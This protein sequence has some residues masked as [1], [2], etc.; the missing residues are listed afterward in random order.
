VTIRPDGHDGFRFQPGQFAWLTA[1]VSPFAIEEHPFSFSS[2]AEQAG[3]MS[4]TI[5]ELGDFTR[6]VRDLVPGQAVYLDGPYGAFSPDRHPAPG[7]VLIAGGVGI[8]PMMSILRTYADRGDRRPILLFYANKTWEDAIFREE[9]DT[10]QQRLPLTVVHVLEQP[11]E[12]WSGEQGFVTAELLDS[13]LP[14]E[15]RVLE[16]FICGPDPM[17]LAVERALYRLRV[18][19][20]RVHAERFNLV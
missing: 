9:I 7:Y 3:R 15:R 8:T 1:W 14:A 20:G 5:K 16:H 19:L 13:R 18:P 12:G 17:R 2:S 6:R 4:F 10:L 11:P